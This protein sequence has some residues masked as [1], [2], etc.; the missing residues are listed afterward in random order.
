VGNSWRPF[1]LKQAWSLVWRTRRHALERDR[2]LLLIAV[3]ALLAIGYE[4]LHESGHGTG[5]IILEVSG[6]LTIYGFDTILSAVAE[7][8]EEAELSWKTV[9]VCV[10][11]ATGLLGAWLLDVRIQS[12]LR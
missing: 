10:V 8:P 5:T 11:A 6:G 12:R 4:R 1:D 2:T 9:W 7:R 3:A